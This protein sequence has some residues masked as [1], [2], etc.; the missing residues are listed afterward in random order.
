MR[1]HQA[2]IVP[3]IPYVIDTQLLILVSIHKWHPFNDVTGDMS[4]AGLPDI[5]RCVIDTHFVFS[6]LELNGIQ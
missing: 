2:V 6:C 4:Q 1:R 3:A 5:A